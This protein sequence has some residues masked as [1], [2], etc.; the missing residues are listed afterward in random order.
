MTLIDDH[1]YHASERAKN[2]SSSPVAL[3][4]WFSFRNFGMPGVTGWVTFRGSRHTNS[5]PLDCSS[6]FLKGSAPKFSKRTILAGLDLFLSGFWFFSQRLTD[7]WRP[8]PCGLLRTPERRIFTR[9][10]H[11]PCGGARP[12]RKC[13]S[14]VRQK[15]VPPQGFSEDHTGPFTCHHSTAGRTES[16]T[17]ASR[18]VAGQLTDD[19]WRAVSFSELRT[20]CFPGG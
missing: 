5:L 8:A 14:A 2:W 4:G 19:V 15:K 10:D 9:M 20:L 18:P 12:L 16:A 11:R 3:S 17:A 6:L 1:R 7:G 13:F